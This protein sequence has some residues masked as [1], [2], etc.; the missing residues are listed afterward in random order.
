MSRELSV[1]E[2]KQYYGGAISWITCICI[3][4]GI[5]AVYKMI[6]SGRGSITLGPFKATWGN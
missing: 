1:Y 5:A 6:F 3:A 2:M 4:G